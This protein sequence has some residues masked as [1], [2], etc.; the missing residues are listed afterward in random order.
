MPPIKKLFDWIDEMYPME[1]GVL[2]VNPDEKFE[3]SDV[4]FSRRG[5]KHVIEQRKA[6]GKSAPEIKEVL[7]DAL[8]AI[9]RF[10][11]SISN[12]N[13]RHLGSIL[14]MRMLD[15][16]HGIVVVL[17]KEVGGRRDIITIHPCRPEYINILLLKN[18]KL[19]TAA[20]GEAPSS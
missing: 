5:T 13:Q 4:R 18:K 6:D 1:K 16:D 19:H 8:L 3:F 11:F 9:T 2:I 14:R 7:K 15:E 20:T 12:P 10:D 17:D